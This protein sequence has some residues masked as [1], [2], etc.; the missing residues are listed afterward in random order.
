MTKEIIPQHVAIIMDGNGR[1][2]R[3][4]HVPKMAGHR[5]GVKAA[6][7]I[8]EAARDMGIKVLNLYTFST[9]NWARPRREI[10]ALFGLLKEYLDKEEDKFNEN[11]VRFSVVGR[12]AG[13][14]VPIQERLKKVMESTKNNTAMRLCLAL[15]YGAR[16]EIINA[17][18]LMAQDAIDGRLSL[19]DIDEKIFSRYLYT[20]EIPDP[21][22]LIRTSGESRISNFLLWQISYS[23]LYFT[24]KLWPDFGRNDLKKAIDEYANRERRFGA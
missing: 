1:W 8:I 14:P 22:L 11:N 13:L 4:R 19:D 6:Q 20:K 18:R 24:K 10:D 9:E 2:A 16:L 7:R 3:A 23:E 15:N 5:A 12:M 21:D 17:A